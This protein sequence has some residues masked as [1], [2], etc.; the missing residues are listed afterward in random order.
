MEFYERYWSKKPKRVFDT[1]P[2]PKVLNEDIIR[3]A[4]KYFKGHGL[5][6]GC[7]VGDLAQVIS[8]MVLVKGIYGADISKTAVSMARARHPKLDFIICSEEALPFKENSFDFVLLA[9]TLE[10]AIDTDNMLSEINYILKRGGVLLV[11][12]TD[13]NWLKK[14]LISFIWET[15]F[16][17]TSPHIRHYSKSSLSEQLRHNGFEPFYHKWNC[18]YFGLMPKGQ[19]VL[20][21]KV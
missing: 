16:Y 6:L 5:D 21:R 4:S 9:D 18:S 10:H 13:Y 17:P 8:E 20:A 7:G 3:L 14:F 2:T 11:S 1:P 15:Y 12:T 19:I